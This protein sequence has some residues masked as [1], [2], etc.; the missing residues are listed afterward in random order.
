LT[1]WNQDAEKLFREFSPGPLTVILKKKD[2]MIFSG[3]L[4]T[5]GCRIPD[6]PLAIE[7]LEKSGPVAAPSLNQSG[8]PSITR[9]EAI[10]K[11]F[12]GKI[13]CVLE[14]KDPELGIE[15]TVV[16]L[17]GDNPTILRPGWIELEEIE[18]VL[19]IKLKKE[20]SEGI[21]L[22][23]GMKYS[24]YAP[25]GVVVLFFEGRLNDKTDA[26]IGFD[27]TVNAKLK[28]IIQNN[29][30]YSKELYSFFMECESSAIQNL[31]CDSPQEG[32]L[33][34]ALDNRLKKAVKSSNS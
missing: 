6:H 17:S 29:Y 26:Y 23:P 27:P 15:S 10:S 13:E 18:N 33:Y 30:E 14:G 21:P 8:R 31:F 4:D 1:Y 34:H 9:F 25:K 28:K 3:N 12:D 19:G 32:P 2:S 24:H 16:D 22:A 5:I 7:F 11:E 20:N